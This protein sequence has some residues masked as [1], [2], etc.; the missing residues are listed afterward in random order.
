[1]HLLIIYKLC[2]RI[3]FFENQFLLITRLSYYQIQLLKS[4]SIEFLFLAK[5]DWYDW[6][7]CNFDKNKI[8][9]VTQ[10]YI[11]QVPLN[12]MAPSSPIS[13][14]CLSSFLSPLVASELSAKF[15]DRNWN[16]QT[17]SIIKSRSPN[18]SYENRNRNCNPHPYSNLN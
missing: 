5:L 6:V 10:Y 16:P 12:L 8:Q 14:I 17:G 13:F 2:I 3:R 11:Y 4:S 7:L 9:C 15:P 18:Q 1:M